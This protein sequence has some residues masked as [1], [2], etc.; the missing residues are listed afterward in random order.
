M[1]RPARQVLVV[2]LVL[3]VAGTGYWVYERFFS[4]DAQVDAMHRACLAEF[5]R[6]ASQARSQLDKGA[7]SLS[8][9]DSAKGVARDVAAGLG[10]VLEEFADNVGAATCGTLREAC[11]LDFDGQVC[12][13]ARKRFGG[14]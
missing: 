4:H 1:D 10:R 13:R 7:A 11:R 2:V 6:G 14:R 3:A 8:R 5:E 9:D 12:A